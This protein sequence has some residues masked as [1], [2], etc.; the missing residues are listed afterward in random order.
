MGRSIQSRPLDDSWEGN[1]CYHD[2][3]AFLWV[4][5]RCGGNLEESLRRSATQRTLW[6][7]ADALKASRGES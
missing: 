5:Y 3:F 1:R 2:L 6:K 7:M 4:L